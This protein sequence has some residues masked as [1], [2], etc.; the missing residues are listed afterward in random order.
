MHAVLSVFCWKLDYNLLNVTFCLIMKGFE[1][2]EVLESDH[3]FCQ[4]Q[5]TKHATKLLGFAM[6]FNLKNQCCSLKE[7]TKLLLQREIAIQPTWTWNN[8]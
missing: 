6:L 1:A 8:S 3:V 5:R 4:G 7:S 2:S